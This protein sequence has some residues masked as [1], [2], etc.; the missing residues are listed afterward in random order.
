[1]HLADFDNCPLEIEHFLG[2]DSRRFF[3][4]DF[5]AFVCSKAQLVCVKNNIKDHINIVLCKPEGF[6]VK[7]EVSYVSLDGFEYCFYTLRHV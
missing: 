4:S 1:M 6:F 7:R 2:S 3:Q 5:Y